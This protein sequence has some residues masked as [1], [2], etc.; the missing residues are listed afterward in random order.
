M[1]TAGKSRV[2]VIHFLSCDKHSGN[3]SIV[4][5]TT[6]KVVF[7]RSYPPTGNRAPRHTKFSLMSA[8]SL[9]HQSVKGNLSEGRTRKHICRGSNKKEKKQEQKQHASRKR[10]LVSRSIFSFFL[11]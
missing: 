5:R 11:L 2:Q 6:K 7:L 3:V 8:C 10:E 9:P 1:T 4:M